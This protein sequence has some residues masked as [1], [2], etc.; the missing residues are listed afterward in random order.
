MYFFH[1]DCL[2][3]DE[4]MCPYCGHTTSDSWELDDEG[5]I[6]CDECNET[7][8]YTR[9]FEVTYSSYKSK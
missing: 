8:K 1:T 5:E 3:T 7:F 6:C 9:N 2:F 4:L